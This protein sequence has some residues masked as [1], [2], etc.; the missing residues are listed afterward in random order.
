MRDQFILTQNFQKFQ[1]LI[2]ELLS[3]QLGLEMAVVLGQAGRGKTTAAR[4]I[5]TMNSRV[6]HVSYVG[7][8]SHAGIIREI[9]FAAAG[10]RPRATQAC[11]D[12]LERS[13]NESR[14]VIMV[15]EADR[16]SL[17]HLNILR[18][19]HDRCCVPIV[20]IGEEPLKGKL[21]QERRLISRTSQELVFQ[22]VAAIDVIQFYRNNLGQDI[23]GGIA[24]DLA[25]HSQG[26]FRLVVKDALR[27]ERTMKASGLAQISEDLVR[28]IC[29]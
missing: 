12:L 27:I 9:C 20:L 14:R 5:V 18:D 23:S 11:F 19:L 16:M 24:T 17:R 4:R 1:A 29:K 2:D 7:W 6:I 13:L 3:H 21:A 15:D 25:R 8:L 22:R 28:E 26:D 10:S